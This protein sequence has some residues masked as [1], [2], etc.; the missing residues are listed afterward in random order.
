MRDYDVIPS[1]K[2]KR[3]VQVLFTLARI[4]AVEKKIYISSVL[5]VNLSIYSK[6]IITLTLSIIALDFFAV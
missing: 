4:V 1:N 6:Q 3:H 2:S 5:F